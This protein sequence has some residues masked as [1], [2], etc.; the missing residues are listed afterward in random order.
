VR[1]FSLYLELPYFLRAIELLYLCLS[2]ELSELRSEVDRFMI[3]FFNK[4]YPQPDIRVFLKALPNL[5]GEATTQLSRLARVL[6]QR[7]SVTFRSFL[8]TKIQW[9]IHGGYLPLWKIVYGNF[10]R[11]DKVGQVFKADDA[12]QTAAME[13][14]T[15]VKKI[16]AGLL[17]GCR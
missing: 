12:C 7:L 8:S 1:R 17:H 10:S 6:Y 2:G 9:G 11:M 5:D 15:A 14:E 13:F 3:D 4:V 16:I